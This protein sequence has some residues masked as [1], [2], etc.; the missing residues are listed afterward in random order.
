MDAARLPTVLP[1]HR[2]VVGIEYQCHEIA[3]LERQHHVLFISSV[4]TPYLEHETIEEV[5]VNSDF[6]VRQEARGGIRFDRQFCLA[7]GSND[8]LREILGVIGFPV[9]L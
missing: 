1:V 2:I 5:C 4:S 6:D 9:T 3:C 7:F 8:V